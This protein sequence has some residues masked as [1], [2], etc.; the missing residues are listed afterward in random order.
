[1]EYILFLPL[2]WNYQL[3]ADECRAYELTEKDFEAMT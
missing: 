2:V 3:L 1:M